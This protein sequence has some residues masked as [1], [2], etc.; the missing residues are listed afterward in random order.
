M[1][2][3]AIRY[4]V[5]VPEIRKRRLYERYETECKT[6]GHTASSYPNEDL[7]LMGSRAQFRASIARTGQV[8]GSL[9]TGI[10]FKE[11]KPA[12]TRRSRD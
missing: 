5:F 7:D 2:R 1:K 8:F 9:W 6:N 4:H 12:E 10:M 3:T 11:R